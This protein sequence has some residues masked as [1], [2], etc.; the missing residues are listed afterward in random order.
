M[1]IALIGGKGYI[2][3][4]LQNWLETKKYEVVTYDKSDHQKAEEIAY[5]N[6][7]DFVVHLAAFPGV[8]NCKNDFER[9]VVDNISS[10]FNVFDKCYNNGIITPCIFISS[11]AAK[12]PENNMYGAIKRIIEVEAERLNKKGADI[13]ILRLTNVYGGIGYFLKKQTVIANIVKAIRQKKD[14]TI[15]GHGDQVRDFIHVDDV[16]KAI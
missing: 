9:A 6:Q 12:F 10:A 15:N 3:I 7:V 4:N 8:A 1:R 13:R 5:F 14:F 2:G 11:Q 16:C